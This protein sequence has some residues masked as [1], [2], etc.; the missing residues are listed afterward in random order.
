GAEVRAVAVTAVGLGTFLA[1]THPA[2]SRSRP[3]LGGASVLVGAGTGGA[4]LVLREVGR[5]AGR[6]RAQAAGLGAAAGL[7]FGLTAGLLKLV[8]SSGAHEPPGVLAVA[9]GCLVGLGLVGTGM[10][11]RAYQL[12]PLSLSLPLVN[13]V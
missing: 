5:H 9:A 13:V 4:L 11:Q 6:P 7:M 3:S 12:A 2:A 10:N 8:G 1:C